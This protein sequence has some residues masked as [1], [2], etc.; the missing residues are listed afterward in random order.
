M[1]PFIQCH[2]TR[3]LALSGGLMNPASSSVPAFP[4]G[5]VQFDKT[6]ATATN[7]NVNDLATLCFFIAGS[8]LS[9]N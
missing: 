3:G 4:V 6:N 9:D 2:Q 5:L 7:N 1:F 8:L